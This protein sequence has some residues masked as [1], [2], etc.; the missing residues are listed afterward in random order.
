MERLTIRNSDGS[1]SQPM[2][3]RWR[4]A[5]AKL[6][7]YEDTGLEPEQVAQMCQPMV[8]VI[9]DISKEDTRRIKKSMEHVHIRLNTCEGTDSDYISRNKAQDAMNAENLIYNLDQVE[10]GDAHRFARAA[11]RV[12]EQIEP[13]DVRPVPPGGI[14]EM[15]DGYHTFNGLY[16]QRMVLFAALV[17]QNKCNAWKS[18]KHE[19]GELCFG[20]GW[21]IVGIDTPEGSYTYHYENKDFDRFDCE[22]LPVGKPWDGHTEKDVTRLLS[23]PDVRPV[24]WGKW[25]AY[26]IIGSVAINGDFEVLSWKCSACGGISPLY[27]HFCPNCGADMRPEGGADG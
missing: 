23:L 7:A 3:L 5:L 24:V 18:H 1:V 11:I 21:F 22:E 14:G 17:K 20:G 15:S 19:N 27:T 2:N 8:A 10:N 16:Y 6:A 26:H 9:G 25:S 12:L 13:A 4:D